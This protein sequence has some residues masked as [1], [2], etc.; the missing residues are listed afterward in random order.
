VLT[1]ESTPRPIILTVRADATLVGA[2][3]IQVDGPVASG[4]SRSSASSGC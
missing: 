4:S 2:G 3:P 1:V